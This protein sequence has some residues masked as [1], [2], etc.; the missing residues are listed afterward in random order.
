MYKVTQ[1]KCLLSNEPSVQFAISSN[2]IK[3]LDLGFL[4]LDSFPFLASHLSHFAVL[5][6]LTRT[7][8]ARPHRIS[9]LL[10]QYAK[11]PHLRPQLVYVT[12]VTFS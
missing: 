2:T 3:P 6:G 1:L 8:L 4:V 10:N 12:I 7:S 5:Q 11:P 9:K